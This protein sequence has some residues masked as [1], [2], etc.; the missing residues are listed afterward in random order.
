LLNWHAAFLL[1]TGVMIAGCSG[2]SPNGGG[3]AAETDTPV[4]L[5]VGQ[6][7]A[8]AADGRGAASSGTARRGS[9]RDEM[10]ALTARG[11]FWSVVLQT[12]PASGGRGQTGAVELL[13]RMQPVDPGLA[14]AFIHTT[15]EGSMVLFGR[16]RSPDSASAQRD[17]AYIKGIEFRDEP[18][19][20][21]A[22]LTRIVLPRDPG[23]YGPHE[24]LSVRVQR[25]WLTEVYTF[26]V[27]AW[28]TFREYARRGE[29]AMSWD[30]VRAA[31]ERQVRELR[32]QGYQAYY[33]HD[34]DKELS[35]VTIGLFGPSAYDAQAGLYV[36]RRLERLAREFPAHLV[37][38][39][40]V[41]MQRAGQEVTQPPLLVAV[42]ELP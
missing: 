32:G 28:G 19:F 20:P 38:G 8:D 1:G 25:S 29:S 24:L 13:R 21:R 22:M 11:S 31:A 10:G 33:H 12:F 16:H 2:S 36:D 40:P 35:M 39:E 6:D 42:P 41:V 26:Q 27:A 5:D 4:S 15:D 18:L 30:E 9:G 37:N 14:D 34:A 7:W 23:S 3:I 17:L